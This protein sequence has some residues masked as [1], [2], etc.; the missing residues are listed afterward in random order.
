M[1]A[2]VTHIILAFATL[3][4]CLALRFM[5]QQE[6]LVGTSFPDI[7]YL[8]V[9]PR[10]STHVTKPHS[11][12][13]QEIKQCRNPFYVGILIHSLVDICQVDFMLKTKIFQTIP[14]LNDD[15]HRLKLFH[16]LVLY[17]KGITWIH[18][19][20]SITRYFDD[21]LFAERAYG[22]SDEM[23]DVWH[24]RLKSYFSQGLDPYVMQPALPAYVLP[25]LEELILDKHLNHT[26]TSGT[27]QF[28]L[29]FILG[30]IDDFHDYQ[31][32]LTLATSMDF[33]DNVL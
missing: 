5:P 25:G 1:A 15:P 29:S 33:E 20:P 10:N 3:F 22:V 17:P 26:L 16:D 19:W 31:K 8:N 11:L 30:I 6:V 2:P 14:E 12:L 24:M 18:D 32:T 13:W 27:H 21:Y 28:F 7:R 4:N 9:V 23:L